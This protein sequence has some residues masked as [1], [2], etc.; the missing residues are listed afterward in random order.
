VVGTS[1]TAPLRVP[2]PRARHR[3]ARARECQ[4]DGRTAASRRRGAAASFGERR[5]E[6]RGHSMAMSGSFQRMA[7]SEEAS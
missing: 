1:L 7:R 3:K 6:V 2:F 5:G 4:Y